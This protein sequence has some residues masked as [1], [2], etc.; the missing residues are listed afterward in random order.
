MG[1]DN[2]INYIISVP[3]WNESKSTPFQLYP[4]S[5]LE[6][7]PVLKIISLFPSEI[8]E[9]TPQA[10]PYYLILR[11]AGQLS[12]SWHL[13][14]PRAIMSQEFPPG[15]P[16][17]FIIIGNEE[18]IRNYTYWKKCRK[19]PEIYSCS[20]F[21]SNFNL[22]FLRNKMSNLCNDIYYLYGE[23][24]FLTKENIL[25]WNI[26]S[27]SCFDVCYIDHYSTYPSCAAIQK[28]GFA[29][30]KSVKDSP[31]YNEII[32]Q[33]IKFCEIIVEIRIKNLPVIDDQNFP[34]RPIVSLY[35]PNILQKRIFSRLN[36]NQIKCA[37]T[38]FSIL[39]KQDGFDFDFLN[40]ENSTHYEE[41]NSFLKIRRQE[42]DLESAAIS[43]LSA[44]E[45]SAVLTFPNK[46]RKTAGIVRQFSEH[47]R[48]KNPNKNKRASLFSRVQKS[49]LH[50]VPSDFLN[51]IS[52]LKGSIRIISDAHLE[53]LDIDGLPLCLRYDTARIPAS[54]GA[55]ILQCLSQDNNILFKQE[56]LYNILIIRGLHKEDHIYN[57]LQKAVSAY[58]IFFNDKIKITLVDTQSK[59]DLVN[60]INNFEGNI[61]IFDGH[62]SHETDAGGVIWLGNK[63]CNVMEIRDQII[64]MPPI[65]I[66]SAC[67]TYAADRNHATTANAFLSLG[68]R[69][70]L[71]S[72]FP[73]NANDAAAFCARLLYRIHSYIPSMIGIK[74]GP[75]SW[76]QV[77]SGML[78]RQFI[79]D[80]YNLLVEKKHIKV[81][82]R[83]NIL[84]E[85][86]M[87]VDLCG[88]NDLSLL[89]TMR[90]DKNYS[91]FFSK[92]FLSKMISID[93]LSNND[94]LDVLREL[95]E[96]KG[97]KNT[98]FNIT[99]KQAISESSSISYLNV[100]R[101]ETVFIVK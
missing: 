41:I 20:D 97:V 51:T 96:K 37:Q 94:Y 45:C 44:S 52:K 49:F 57:L 1:I 13:A 4:N 6:K 85:M 42:L 79:S 14:S 9:L 99:L 19:T 74:N 47:Y 72:V 21:I 38:A 60:A 62:G 15:K 55:I 17:S 84:A 71:S 50:N 98:D 59:E 61:I 75:V 66:L 16:F 12:M 81:S 100:G 28:A 68:C 10:A 101:P 23:D 77:I 73:L 7:I 43:I 90:D 91:R 30:K 5:I 89:R 78:R 22:I 69:S 26:E 48:A 53:W 54:P 87:I 92:D 56:D 2:K 34:E 76:T 39:N 63:P 32:E 33:I 18:D 64:K 82:A 40:K 70:V 86:S 95:L 31:S 25:S 46:I 36:E 29:V 65:V 24:I 67:D 83:D 8:R 88:N 80:F 27:N 3:D 35:A 93:D 11:G 58:K